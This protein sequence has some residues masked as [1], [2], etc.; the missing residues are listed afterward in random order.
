MVSEPIRE[1]TPLDLLLENREELV[2]DLGC[3]GH[4]DH[5]MLEFS[6]IR[7]V[8]S[9]VS[10]TATLDFQRAN[11]DLLRRLVGRVH[12]EAV[13]KGKGFQDG[14]LFFKKEFAKA[15]EQV[16]PMCQ[17]MS[18]RQRLAWLNIE[19]WLHLMKKKVELMIFGRRGRQLRRTTKML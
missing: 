12:R 11:F 13:L 16:L 5:E 2:G 6:V 1:D 10:K 3:L 18:Q 17:K 19:L 9:G 8:R 14:W 4:S 7:P 15:Q